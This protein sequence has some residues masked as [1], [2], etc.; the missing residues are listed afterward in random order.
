MCAFTVKQRSDVSAVGARRGRKRVRGIAVAQRGGALRV[1]RHGK[2]DRGV[3][4]V[5]MEAQP[6]P[7]VTHVICE[8]RGQRVR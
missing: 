3:L 4:V 6:L 7:S 2:R 1:N 5:S 8:S